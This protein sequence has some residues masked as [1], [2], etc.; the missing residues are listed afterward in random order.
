MERYRI[1]CF[2][3]G[4]FRREQRGRTTFRAT[5]KR[6]FSELGKKKH[7]FKLMG[8]LYLTKI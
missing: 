8:W 5:F 3:N 6:N 4:Y 2:S 1:Q 7:A